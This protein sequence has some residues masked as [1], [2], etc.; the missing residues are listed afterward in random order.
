MGPVSA[1]RIREPLD[2]TPHRPLHPLLLLGLGRLT[3]TRGEVVAARKFKD[4]DPTPLS[5]D[6]KQ[7]VEGAVRT[8]IRRLANPRRHEEDKITLMDLEHNK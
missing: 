5:A 1:L 7:W 8:L 4:W 6:D 2:E 3:S